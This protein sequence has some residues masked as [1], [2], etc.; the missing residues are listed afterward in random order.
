MQAYAIYVCIR[1]KLDC[2][3]ECVTQIFLSCV[4][5]VTPF[6]VN[7]KL[8]KLLDGEFDNVQKE[9]KDV[10]YKAGVGSLMYAMV[11]TKVDVTF[12]VSLV[13]QFLSK[14]SPPHWMAMKRIMRHLKNTLDSELYLRGKV[15]TL[16]GFCDANWTEDANDWQSKTGYMFIIGI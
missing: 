2:Y 10:P 15:I 4:T 9:M 1:H 14:A 5:C 8:F 7:S 6:N 16:R 11:A 13:S 12:A 3:L